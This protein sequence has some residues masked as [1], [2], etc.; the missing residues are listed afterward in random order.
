MATNHGADLAAA[1]LRTPTT[2]SYF[3]PSLTPCENHMQHTTRTILDT[4][5]L[6]KARHHSSLNEYQTCSVTRMFDRREG[7]ATTWAYYPI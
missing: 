2:F 4:Y 7:L 6:P 5:D 1:N 3:A